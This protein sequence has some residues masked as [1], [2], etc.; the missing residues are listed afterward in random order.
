MGSFDQSK[1][2]NGPKDLGRQID[3]WRVKLF[4]NSFW[5]DFPTSSTLYWE[6]FLNQLREPIK[7]EVMRLWQKTWADK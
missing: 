2:E 4:Y 6:S 7:N 5:F 3:F 1:M